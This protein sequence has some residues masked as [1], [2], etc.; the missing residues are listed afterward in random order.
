M[1][2]YSESVK[3]SLRN[4]FTVL[5]CTLL[6]TV[7]G[8]GSVA[9]AALEAGL[10]VVGVE[11]DG[12]ALAELTGALDPVEAEA[13]AVRR[14]WQKDSKRHWLYYKNGKA[15]KNRWLKVSGKWYLFNK[16]GYAL[17]GWH[18]RSGKWYYMNTS[19]YAMQTGWIKVKKVWYYLDPADGHMLTGWIT[20]KGKTYYMQASGAMQTGWLTLEDKKYCF[21]TSGVMKT[22]WY[23][24]D[25][26]KY[27]FGTDGV[28][29]SG[30]QTIDGKDYVFAEDGALTEPAEEAAAAAAEAEAARPAVKKKIIV[31][32]PGHSAR[33]PGGSVPLGPGSKSMKAADAIGTR[34]VATRIYE[35]ELV[36]T[37]SVKLKAELE[38]RGYEV[39]LTRSDSSSAHSCIDRAKVANDKK[40]DV[41]IRVHANG[42][43]NKSATGAMTICITK[44][45]PYI[46]NMY[47]KSKLLS[48]CVLDSYVK[49]T[50]CRK[51]YV[52]ETDSM[53]G[54]NWSKVPT[55]LIELGYMTNA[56]ED[57]KMATSAYQTKM[58]KGMADGIDAYFKKL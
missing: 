43:T 6:L 24:R 48:S 42:S 15:V 45:N 57:K 32:D 44:N 40:A 7:T 21:G 31:I 9:G 46:K 38:K 16:S 51:E 14:G 49:A 23:T 18:Q 30:A 3:K 47:A 35:Y 1:N 28:M 12:S 58:V 5:V 54:N 26:K 52:W 25:G 37:V 39:Y 22:G 41:F 2:K 4:L 50:G 36:L 10:S 17:K 11:T 56:A 13:A 53:T 19:S 33:M 55:T 8:L 29:V 27:Y 34:G 20:V